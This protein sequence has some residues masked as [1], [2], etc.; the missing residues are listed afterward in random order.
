[1]G[2]RSSVDSLQKTGTSVCELMVLSDIPEWLCWGG[3]LPPAFLSN[4]LY[5]PR[6]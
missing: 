5:L 1:M 6:I 2:R 3:G 4:S